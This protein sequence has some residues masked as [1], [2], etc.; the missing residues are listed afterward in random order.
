[1]NLRDIKK[2]IEFFIGEFIE[3][4]ELFTILNPQQNSEEIDAIVDESVDLYNSLKQRAAHPEGPKKAYYNGLIK[5]M[6][7]KLDELSEKLS[8]VVAKQA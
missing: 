5:E 3:D 6:F 8:S 1:M 4:C 2:D 7:E